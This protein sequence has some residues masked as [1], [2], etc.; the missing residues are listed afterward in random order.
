MTQPIALVGLAAGLSVAATAEAGT[1]DERGELRR[2][3][4]GL[5]FESDDD[6]PAITWN[7][8]E[9]PVTV[10]APRGFA[11]DVPLEGAAAL[12][13]R[14]F[15]PSSLF[16]PL[17]GLGRDQRIEV[18]LWMRNEGAASRA[19]L[20]WWS[21]QVSR[22]LEAGTFDQ[23]TVAG[24]LVFTP[25]E[26]RTS[27][28]WQEWTSGPV[29]QTLGGALTPV[30]WVQLLDPGGTRS[31]APALWVDA[32]EVTT[33]GA[34][35]ADGRACTGRPTACGP[36][37]RCRL[38]RCVD[39]AIVDG[40]RFASSNL[41]DQYVDR[42]RF[43]F[44]TFQAHRRAREL[45]AQTTSALEALEGDEDFWRQLG[46]IIDETQDGHARRP[47]VS[48]LSAVAPGVCLVEGEAD[49]LPGAPRRPMVFR[50]A[51]DHPAGDRLQPGDVL[52]AIDGVDVEQWRS[53]QAGRF[54]F[55]GDP[56]VRRFAEIIQ[57]A[58][59]AAVD[60][61]RLT[62]SR[63]AGPCSDP[64]LIEVDYADLV[65]PL[66]RNEA[67]PWRTRGLA[68]DA[69]F[70]RIDDPT[71]GNFDHVASETVAGF[72]ILQFNGTLGDGFGDYASWKTSIANVLAFEL[73]GVVLDQRRGDGGSFQGLF[74]LTSFFFEPGASPIDLVTPWL[75]DREPDPGLLQE[76]VE[77]SR[78]G[79]GFGCGGGG[80]VTQAALA[81]EAP[82]V[83]AQANAK[84]AVLVGLNVSGNDWLTDHLRRRRAD[85]S[86][87]RVFGPVPTYGAFGQV[88]VLP[89]YGVGFEGPRLQWTG[90]FVLPRDGTPL[91]GVFDA[92][93]DG[94]GV[95]PDVVVF[96]KQ[97]DALL[98]I[99]TQR[100]EALQWLAQP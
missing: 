79:G 69:R 52:T 21:G 57:I 43:E 31:G 45:R 71:V 29:D 67:L 23:L 90:G 61:S 10:A 40:P 83:G 96:Q 16:V 32:I 53:E 35:V 22:Q 75:F 11:P 100:Q 84:V 30:L 34:A 88:T 56:E 6:L 28:G 47:T 74:Y 55:S 25:T 46:S 59:A 48:G 62:F 64:E 5:G 65:A 17:N 66:W 97:S 93:L 33:L 60:G 87:T 95:R 49:L 26:R 24:A 58:N 91:A 89:T 86:R 76:L 4:P 54:S 99:D 39:A 9:V 2:D 41:R 19:S 98:G 37:S 27:D 12:E 63:C 3:A 73:D 77:C 70:E 14:R 42:R 13:L 81:P 15:G 1:F 94:R 44:E 36:G 20:I 80:W 72:P 51:S 50:T 82:S 38:G 18:R 92:P 78:D 68:C 7:V 8:R 85:P